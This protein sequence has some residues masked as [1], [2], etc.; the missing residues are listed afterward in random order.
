VLELTLVPAYGRDYKSKAECLAAWEAGKDFQ[1]ATAMSPDAGRYT[2]IRDAK[3]FPGEN[4]R[5]RY[6]KLRSIVSIPLVK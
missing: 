2:S 1:I 5:I 6:N 4:V 3:E